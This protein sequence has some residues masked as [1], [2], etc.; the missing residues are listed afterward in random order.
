MVKADTRGQR[1]LDVFI[2]NC[3]YLW[4]SPVVSQGLVRSD[5]LTE[6][7]HLVLVLS[8]PESLSIFVM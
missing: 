2:T 4:K 5:H 7:V 1:I 3:P 6:L 8:L